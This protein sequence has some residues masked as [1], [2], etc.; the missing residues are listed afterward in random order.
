MFKSDK[1]WA[2]LAVVLYAL[3]IYSF[4]ATPGQYVPQFFH[5]ADKFEHT[6]EYL[7]FGFLILRAFSKSHSDLGLRTLLILLSVIMLYALSDE[8]HQLFVP[9]RVFSYFDAAFDWIGG[10]AGV[11]LYKSKLIRWLK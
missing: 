6:L 10:L 2:W 5:G 11:F 8:V 3:V 7:P 9:G 4:S 1:T